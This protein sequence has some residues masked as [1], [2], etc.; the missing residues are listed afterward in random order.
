MSRLSRARAL[1]RDSLRDERPAG[2][3]GGKIHHV[4][5]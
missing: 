3:A 2:D 1:L 4:N 5:V